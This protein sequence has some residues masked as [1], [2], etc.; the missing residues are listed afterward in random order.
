MGMHLPKWLPV[1]SLLLALSCLLLPFGVQAETSKPSASYTVTVSNDKPAIGET[2][3]VRVQ[4]SNLN[5]VY[6]F[7]INLSYD[8]DVLTFMNAKS[9]W[10]GFSIPPIV[11]D[12]HVQLAHTLVG[13]KPGLSDSQTFMTL[14]FKTAHYGKAE[15]VLQSVKTVDSKLASAS[16]SLSQQVMLTVKSPFAFDDLEGFEWGI[17]AIEALAAKGIINGTGDR[18][19]SP[20][21]SIS[22]ADYVVMLM[23][24]LGVKEAASTE[25]T[26]GVEAGVMFDDVP[27]D[28]YYAEAV[29]AAKQLGIV[30]GDEHGVFHPAAPVTREDMI[31]L[32]DRTLHAVKASAPT[33]ADGATSLASYLDADA[34]SDYARASVEAF[35]GLDLIHGYDDGLWPQARSNRAQAAVLLYNILVKFMKISGS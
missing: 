27:G 14:R 35:V 5:D 12:N 3:E 29:A 20:G 26:A 32:A 30:Q 11:T 19:F 16:V 34:I 10:P 9:E 18:T 33:M 8:A 15:L 23:R 22:R 25:A 6:A 13:K 21:S 4:G 28:A 31:V 17:P 1:Q 24:A 7:E 2:L